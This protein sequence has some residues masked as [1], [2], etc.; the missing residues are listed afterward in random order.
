MPILDS[1]YITQFDEREDDDTDQ[2]ANKPVEEVL[3][4]LCIKFLYFNL[5]YSK[6][7]I[8]RQLCLNISIHKYPNRNIKFLSNKKLFSYFSTGN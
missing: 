5:S 4:L 7:C 3:L 2:A 1:D 8:F 6:V